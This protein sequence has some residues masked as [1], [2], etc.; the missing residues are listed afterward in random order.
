MLRP[1]AL[2]FLFP[3]HR[4]RS[5]YERF[6]SINVLANREKPFH[7][8]L[9][10]VYDEAGN[11]IDRHAHTSEFEERSTIHTPDFAQNNY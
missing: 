10:R 11:V 2:A 4:H 5:V 1:L 7:D 9:I 3:R 8:A 6:E